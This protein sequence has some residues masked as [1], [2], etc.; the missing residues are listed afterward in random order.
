MLRRCMTLTEQT[1]PLSCCVYAAR[2][3]DSS[4]DTLACQLQWQLRVWEGG[5]HYWTYALLPKC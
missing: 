3:H 2:D 4:L 5:Y 1:R